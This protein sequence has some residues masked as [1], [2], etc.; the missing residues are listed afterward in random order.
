M[1][2][3]SV[4]T[5]LE[6]EGQLACVPVEPLAVSLPQVCLNHRAAGAGTRRASDKCQR[7]KRKT[8]NGD[9]LLWAMSTLGFEEYV[10]PLKVYLAKFREVRGPAGG[11]LWHHAGSV[12]PLIVT[13]SGWGGRWA[14][15][16][17]C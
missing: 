11:A 14:G 6:R 16:W 10:E 7:E 1:G 9:D 12:I 2:R 4:S 3:L 15:G 17:A 5:L 8:I 13:M